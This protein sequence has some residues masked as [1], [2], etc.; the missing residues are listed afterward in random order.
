MSI[1]QQI[2]EPSLHD[3]W[4]DH[5]NDLTASF[6]SHVV[7]SFA[8]TIPDTDTDAK[9]SGGDEEDRYLLDSCQSMLRSL[10]TVD[11]SGSDA[12]I[13]H[14]VSS[15]K[16]KKKKKKQVVAERLELL[17]GKQSIS[18]SNNKAKAFTDGGSADAAAAVDDEFLRLLPA[19][20]ALEHPDSP[21]RL[22]AIKRILSE[23]EE[24]ASTDN[25]MVEDSDGPG[26]DEVISMCRSL[27]RRYV[28]DDDSGV[29]AA[30]ASAIRRLVAEGIVEEEDLFA[31][32]DA[33]RNV[34]TGLLKW[35]VLD[36]LPS[37]SS[38]VEL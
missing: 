38:Y 7:L 1:Y 16:G 34:I 15:L 2:K 24:G 14:A 18:S 37:K 30:A 33:I 25:E 6:A 10:R 27:L 22:D 4:T 11:P 32:D 31:D 17:L 20:V 3:V 26:L 5:T 13:A 23:C 8:A 9:S 36:V 35:S 21:I 29:A 28:A 12:G 19:R